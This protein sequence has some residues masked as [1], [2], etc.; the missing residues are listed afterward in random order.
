MMINA[1]VGP[2]IYQFEL[3]C[4][5]N[6]DFQ[7][8]KDALLSKQFKLISKSHKILKIKVFFAV[9]EFYSI[10]KMSKHEDESN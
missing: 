10:D 9:F 1:I 6:L 2:N 8:I 3:Y 4:N 7:D 5:L